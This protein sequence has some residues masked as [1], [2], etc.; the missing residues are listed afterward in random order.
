MNAVWQLYFFVVAVMFKHNK[1]HWHPWLKIAVDI[2]AI[3]TSDL[4]RN[5]E[6]VVFYVL[7]KNLENEERESR[8]KNVKDSGLKLENFRVKNSWFVY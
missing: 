6:E 2:V 4:A 7:A 5:C 3:A 8:R 1:L